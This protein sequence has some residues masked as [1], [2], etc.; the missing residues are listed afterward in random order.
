MDFSEKNFILKCT[1]NSNESF[2]VINI[3]LPSGVEFKNKR[4]E[5]MNSI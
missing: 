5:E 3:H 4:E 1:T 2:Y